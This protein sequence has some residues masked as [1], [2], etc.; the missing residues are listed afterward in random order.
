[1][2]GG[3]TLCLTGHLIPN[4]FWGEECPMCR[5]QRIIGLLAYDGSFESELDRI[6][7]IL[8]VKDEALVEK[9]IGGDA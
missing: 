7:E 1:M 3:R 2:E 8:K 9:Y 6:C 5:F 4:R